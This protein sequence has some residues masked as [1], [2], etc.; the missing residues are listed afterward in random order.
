MDKL[1]IKIDKAWDFEGTYVE[2][3]PCHQLSAAMHL[4]F[5]RVQVGNSL[6][7]GNALYNSQNNNP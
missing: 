3:N 1:M 5:R 4:Y 7:A 2:T 6:K